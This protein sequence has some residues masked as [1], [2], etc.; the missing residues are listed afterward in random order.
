MKAELSLEQATR[1]AEKKVAIWSIGIFGGPTLSELKPVHGIEMPVLSAQHVTDVAAEF[2]PDTILLQVLLDVRKIESGN[3]AILVFDVFPY[4]SNCFGAS[5]VP[6]DSSFPGRFVFVS[7][8][9]INVQ[10]PWELQG[11]T[12]AQVKVTI[13]GFIFGNV[14]TVPVADA[15]PAFFGVSTRTDHR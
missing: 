12:S 5:E 10:V 2:V 1:K 7:P 14:V 3:R 4:G 6:D 9:Q 8:G 11:Y 13:D 15:T